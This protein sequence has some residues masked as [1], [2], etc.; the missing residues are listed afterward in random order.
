MPNILFDSFYH[1]SESKYSKGQFPE[2]GTLT[3]ASLG[4]Y[5]R[6]FPNKCS[7]PT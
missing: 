2:D 3:T 4:N 7:A 6:D 5:Q 1:L